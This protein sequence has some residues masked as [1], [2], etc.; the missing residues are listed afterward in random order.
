MSETPI[1]FSYYVLIILVKC[2]GLNSVFFMSSFL[3]ILCR[4]MSKQ[5]KKKI[6]QVSVIG[7]SVRVLKF[8]TKTYKQIYIIPKFFC[9]IL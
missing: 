2:D 5:K 3:L 1:L 6:I 7:K 8:F 4:L 9:K